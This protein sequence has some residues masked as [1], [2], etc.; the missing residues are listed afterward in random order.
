[1][2]FNE[3]VYGPIH[4]R[5]LGIS[6][7]LNTMP[8]DGKLC[9]FDCIYCECGL[10]KPFIHPKLPTVTEFYNAL[11]TKLKKLRQEQVSLD[12]LTFSGNGEPTLHPQFNPY[13]KIAG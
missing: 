5:R 9:S 6:L 10:N 1:M 7:G 3:I 8:T 13:F 12:V 2:L 11:E 4:S